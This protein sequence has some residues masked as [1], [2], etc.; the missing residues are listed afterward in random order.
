MSIRYV[1]ATA[2]PPLPATAPP[3]PVITPD[4]HSPP[5]NISYSVTLVPRLE[6]AVNSL[7]NI[8]ATLSDKQCQIKGLNMDLVNNSDQLDK[9]QIAA[10]KL[11]YLVTFSLEVLLQIKGR[12]RQISHIR[13]IP[14]ILLV[15]IPMVRTVSA[16]LFDCLPDCSQRLSEISVHLGSIVLDSAFL[17]TAKFDFSRSNSESSILYDKVKLIVGSKLNKQYPNLDIF[18]LNDILQC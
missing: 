7:D 18:K 4:T 5:S 16:Q 1:T 3:L 9:T 17:T 6:Y 8:V 13:S 15:T 11:E 2:P 14:E 10:L 12:T